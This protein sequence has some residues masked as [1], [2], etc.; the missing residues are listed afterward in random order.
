M[1][2]ELPYAEYVSLINVQKMALDRAAMGKG[3]ERHRPNDEPFEEQ[4]IVDIP[5]R[6]KNSGEGFNLGQII[7][8]AYEVDGFVGE[9]DRKIVEMLDIMNYASGLVILYHKKKGELDKLLDI[10]NG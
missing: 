3:A 5:H 7:K 9:W 1:S 10:D 6:L 4:Q 2:E 8:K